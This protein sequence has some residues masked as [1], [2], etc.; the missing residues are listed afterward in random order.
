MPYAQWRQR[1]FFVSICS[2][3]YGAVALILAATGAQGESRSTLLAYLLIFAAYIFAI[4]SPLIGQSSKELFSLSFLLTANSMVVSATGGHIYTHM[5]FIVIACLVSLYRSSTV[6]VSVIVFSVLYY[7]LVG[8]VSPGLIFTDGLIGK[9][10]FDWSLVL[11]SGL[12]LVTTLSAVSW[13]IDSDLNENLISLENA[14]TSTVL[15]DRK[16]NELQD[17]VLQAITAAMYLVGDEQSPVSRSLQSALDDSKKIVTMLRSK[18]LLTNEDFVRVHADT[19][20]ANGPVS[21]N[22]N[23]NDHI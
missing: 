14:V 23:P 13:L 12:V 11:F 1:H 5:A 6:A 22:E 19:D 7:M 18:E 21:T 8:V 16:V 15:R 2:Q 9:D 17:N 20:D 3:I 10:A 4:R